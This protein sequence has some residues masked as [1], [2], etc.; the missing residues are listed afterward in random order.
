MNDTKTE[1]NIPNVNHFIFYKST[2]RFYYINLPRLLYHNHK[3]VIQDY[4]YEEL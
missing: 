3:R 2:L 1:Y 4:Q